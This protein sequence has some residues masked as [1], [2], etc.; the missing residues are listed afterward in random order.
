[1]SNNHLVFTSDDIQKELDQLWSQRHHKIIFNIFKNI[2]ELE[3]YEFP[4][5]A[6]P[7]ENIISYSVS[8][9]RQQINKISGVGSSLSG[10]LIGGLVAGDVGAIIGSRKAIKTE[11]KEVD[12]REVRIVYSLGKSQE[13]K[14]LRGTALIAL[15]KLIPDKFEK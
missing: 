6:I 15:D 2:E 5:F 14:I 13:M 10:A 4:Y 3:E 9:T 12:N 8:G 7:I 11:L 1:V